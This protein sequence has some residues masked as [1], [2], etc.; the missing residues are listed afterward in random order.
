MIMNAQPAISRIIAGVCLTLMAVLAPIANFGVLDSMRNATGP[1]TD[2]AA[3]TLAIV[4]LI[5]VVAA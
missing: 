3:A 5:A 1:L 2:S 4:C